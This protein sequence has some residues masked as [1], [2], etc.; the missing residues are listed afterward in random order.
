MFFYLLYFCI[1]YK[2]YYNISTLFDNKNI[3]A[4]KIEKIAL[5]SEEVKK[6]D[7]N[8]DLELLEKI[9]GLL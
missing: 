2:T 8:P 1:F 3:M 6:F 7:S 9:T 5:Y 4:T